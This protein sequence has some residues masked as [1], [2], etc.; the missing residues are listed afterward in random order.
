[1]TRGSKVT[2]DAEGFSYPADKPAKRIDYT[3]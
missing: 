1:M 3:F 2:K